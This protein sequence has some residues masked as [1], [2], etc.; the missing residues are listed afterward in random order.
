MHSLS[1]VAVGLAAGLHGALYGAYKDSPHESFLLHRFVR[2]IVFALVISVALVVWFPAVLTE[3][4]FVVFLSVFAL[5]RTATEFWKLFL[6]VEPQDEFRIPTQMHYVK[7]VVHNPVVRLLLGIGFLASIYGIYHLGRIIPSEWPHPVRGLL[8][9]L[10]IGVA[11]G[12]AGGYKDGAIEGF[13]WHKFVKSPF[14]GALGGLIASG[15]TTHPGFL[16]LASIGSMRMFLELLFKMVVPD[17]APGKFRSMTGP[18]T[19]WMTRRRQFLAPYAL[20]WLLYVTLCSH[21][22]W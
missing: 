13:Y 12:I 10:A 19:E 8:T 21:P 9:G 18:F 17:Y 4:A 3:S 22:N 5:T 14:F 1:I 7:G 2:E 6:R 16:L 11:E 15:H 20:T